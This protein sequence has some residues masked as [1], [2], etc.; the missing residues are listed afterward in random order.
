[1]NPGSHQKEGSQAA[2][3]AVNSFFHR[4]IRMMQAGYSRSAAGEW[5]AGLD[6]SKL[7]TIR[8]ILRQN[9]QSQNMVCPMDLVSVRRQIA[10]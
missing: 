9:T 6:W 5:Q 7:G 3:K 8:F 1:L 10:R 2:G 4:L